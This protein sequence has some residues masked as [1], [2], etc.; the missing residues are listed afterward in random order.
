MPRRPSQ[1]RTGGVAS[2]HD[3][4]QL[5]AGDADD[6]CRPGP[7][8]ELAVTAEQHLIEPDRGHVADPARVLDQRC[9]MERDGVHHG[10]PITTQIG[11][12]LV[13]RSAVMADLEGRPSTPLDP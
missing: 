6:L 8:S 4:E 3:I 9:S 1:K 5:A 13:D 7:V 11:S 12:D 10:V 2:R